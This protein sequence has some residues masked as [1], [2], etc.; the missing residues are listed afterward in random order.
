MTLDAI[1][2]RL[3]SIPP[4]KLNGL[5]KSVQRLLEEDM[6]KLIE[7]AA[8]LVEGVCECDSRRRGY[9]CCYMTCDARNAAL[10]IENPKQPGE[11]T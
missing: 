10:E 5:S 3:G 2:A 11:T 8:L 6:P 7:V 9:E 1:K 4:A